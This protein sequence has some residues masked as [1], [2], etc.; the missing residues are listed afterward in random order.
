MDFWSE[1][2]AQRQ[3]ANACLKWLEEET[4][5]FTAPASSRFHGS[6]PG[7]L[8]IHSV[9]VCEELLNLRENHYV[10]EI[11]R[12][13]AIIVALLHDV[14]KCNTYKPVTKRQRNKLGEWVDVKTYEIADTLPMGHGEKSLYLVQKSGLQLTDTEAAAIRWHMGAYTDRQNLSMM[15]AAFRRWPLA[16]FLHLADM[17]AANYVEVEA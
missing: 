6:R 1:A 16:L 15:G 14:C 9:N 12:A 4:D 8:L 13:S 2:T 5:Y 11:D 10:A 7:G 3:G 17:I